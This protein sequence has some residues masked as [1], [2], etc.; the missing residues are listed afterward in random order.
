[1]R[2]CKDC[3]D[4]LVRIMEILAKMLRDGDETTVEIYELRQTLAVYDK[5]HGDASEVLI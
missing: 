1:M 2:P 4:N 3:T 5:C